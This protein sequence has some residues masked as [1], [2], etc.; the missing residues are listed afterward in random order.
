MG[1]PEH[2]VWDYYLE[3]ILP[4]VSNSDDYDQLEE[5]PVELQIPPSVYWDWV[6]RDRRGESW[7]DIQRRRNSYDWEVEFA[8]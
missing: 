2:A 1:V 7:T 3:E 6:D 5:D 4:A 8:V